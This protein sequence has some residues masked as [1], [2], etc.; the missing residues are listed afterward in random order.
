LDDA[1]LL[2]LNGVAAPFAVLLSSPW[3]LA[4]VGAPLAAYLLARR[5]HRALL[6]IVLAVG[7]A[8]LVS[9]EL[10]KP[11]VNRPRPCHV[12]ADLALPDGCGPGKSF[13]SAHA[14]NGF[15]LALAA[16]G[17]FPHGYLVLVPLAAAVAVSR[18]MLGVHY[19][20][21]VLA[22]AAL[23]AAL[24]ALAARLR[25]PSSPRPRAPAATS[26]PDRPGPSPDRS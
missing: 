21:D 7:V 25:T 18:V 6:S 13:P 19:P 1:L 17:T 26:S 9:A 2:A 14:A 3:V 8:N 16:G 12:R 23:G 15:A 20:S 10:L 4:I 22:G 5:A 11:L 24:G